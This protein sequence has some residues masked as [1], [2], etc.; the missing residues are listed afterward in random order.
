MS[1]RAAYVFKDKY[2]S[3]SVYKHHDG[4][5]EGAK[6]FIAKALDFSWSL[7]R[8][9]SDEF[10]AG[11]VAA[12]KESVFSIAERYKG[13]PLDGKLR[14]F[15]GEGV[16]LIPGDGNGWKKFAA[17]LEYVYEITCVDGQLKVDAWSVRY[18]DKT[19][20][21]MKSIAGWIVSPEQVNKDW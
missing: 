20:W 21:E 5:P 7:P 3:V 17:D 1:T 14:E 19:G 11:F 8:Y 10:A 18:Q 13:T 6:H 16:R 15:V 2:N 9:E 12:N 4:Y